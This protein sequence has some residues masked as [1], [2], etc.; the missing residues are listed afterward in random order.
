MK[1]MKID[2]LGQFLRPRRRIN[3]SLGVLL[4]IQ[5]A[6]ALLL[7][8]LPLTQ[9]HA[10]QLKQARVSQ[11]IKDVKLLPAQAAPRP[12]SVSDE[13]R[14]G[15]AVRTG[16]ESRAELTFTDQTLARLGAN[17]IFSFNEGTRN[18]EL[19]GGAMLLRVPKNAGGAQINTAAVTAAITGTTIMLEYHPDAYIKFIVL[20]G[21]GRI[22]RKDHMG[23]S[24]LLHAGQMLIVNPK[25]KGL[26][27]PVDVDLDRL[28]KTSL[29]ING[30]APLPSGDLIAREISAQDEKKHEGGLIETNLVIFG[31]GTAVALLDPTHANLLDQAN[32]N[33][34]R[35]PTPSPTETP[36]PTTP[37]PSTP[38]PTPSKTGTPSV[39]ASST[40]YEINSGTI[41]QTDPAITT[42]G[43]TDFGKIYR[44]PELDG[45]A[46]LWFFGA[47]RDFDSMIGFDE[48][49]FIGNL[50]PVAAFKFSAL[51]LIGNPTIVIG[52]GGPNN[53]ALISVGDLTSGPPG[54]VLDFSNLSLLFLATQDG[55]ITL[56]SDLTF[57]NIPT[58]GVYAR[59]AG[60]SLTFDSS[61]SGTAIVGLVS[62]G[63]IEATNSLTIAEASGTS[64]PN[65]FIISL[66]A[67]QTINIGQD[68]NLS[69]T[70]SDLMTTAL[71]TVNSLGDTN[72][73]G[74]GGINL[75]IDNAESEIQGFAS[76]GVLTGGNLTASTLNLLLDNHDGGL[77]DGGASIFFN[78]VGTFTTGGDANL[79][80]NN[81]DAGGTI[82]LL[83]S[84]TLTAAEI[85]IGGTLDSIIANNNGGNISGDAALLVSSTGA[86]TIGGDAG[87]T[88]DNSAFG[89]AGF[90]NGGEITSSATILLLAQNTS[91]GGGLF[92]FLFNDGGGHIGGAASI[93][94]EFTGNL[95]TQGDL[96]FDVQNS[97]DTNGEVTLPGGAID[98]NATVAVVV[99]GDLVGGSV[100][101]FAVLNNDFRFLSQ[102]GTI[103][104]DAG[105]DVTAASISTASFFQPLVNNTNGVI[106]GGASITVDVTGD[107]SVGTEAFFNI[108]NSGGSIGDDALSSVTAGNLSS[109]ST[110]AFQI[111][112]DGGGTIGGD[113]SLGAAL[114]GS[115]TSPSD[116]FIQILNGTGTIGGDALID[117]TAASISVNNLFTQ[118]DNTGGTIGGNAAIDMNV[119]GSATVTSDA[120]VQILGSDG[121]ATAAINING[122]SYDA[123]GTFLALIDGDGAITFNNVSI[124]ADVLKV[125]ALGTNG[126]LNIGGGILSGDTTLEL[127]ASGS[128]G[129]IDFVSNVTLNSENSVLIAANTV[130]IN[131]SVV[132]TITGD[133]GVNA[134]VF[135]NVPNYTGSGGNGS[136]S[137]TFAGN[138]AQTQ[139]LDQA[140]PFGPS[141][142]TPTGSTTSAGTT[143]PIPTTD[144]DLPGDRGS[145]GDTIIPRGKRHVAIA[146]VT[147]S[148]ELLN[149]ADRVTSTAH[150]RPNAPIGRISRGAG[151]V[152][153]GTGQPSRLAPNVASADLTLSRS[154]AR[155]AVALP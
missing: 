53:L 60:S 10:A 14:E 143:A 133:D 30:F 95:T 145:G 34:E 84:L 108:L 98:G 38:P 110:F 8:A 86:L 113:A 9:L 50:A 151:S 154:G 141:G 5:P 94:A 106:G 89:S 52:D 138:G 43:T 24:V 97:A 59:G 104:G 77:L 58:L 61:V 102:G 4:R 69:I 11:V 7:L 134:S 76:L 28:M 71:I 62:E 88:I 87:F 96:F 27:D 23:E 44:G 40:P 72:V 112:N 64:A 139:P 79:V 90:L 78:I 115:L 48:G 136:T 119:S 132:V 142:A 32:A 49:I 56:S 150:S 152:V 16:V 92:T 75:T 1:T 25:A 74:D 118:I 80:L 101:E 82:D 63:N 137:G 85:S 39:I 140:P 51:S 99:A 22:F 122:G 148:N 42:N 130:T 127:Y 2:S 3:F 26:P 37:P 20:E 15:T 81:G 70:N 144:P 21:T 117:V 54:G 155:R 91:V 109:G 66:L 147:D 6:R 125:G 116:A 55:S 131:N 129:S 46:S 33:E 120:T 73:N 35:Q 124:H 45:P 111:L 17:T 67:G 121:A 13:V 153:S 146:R 36:P 126:A 149:L 135:T 65:G 57:Q 31:D 107:I 103:S 93:V 29:L 18:L 114:S 41:I 105:V 123:G 47:T 128:N 12:A 19:G 68:L 83:S 100:G